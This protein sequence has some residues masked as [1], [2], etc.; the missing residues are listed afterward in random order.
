[1]TA[2]TLFTNHYLHDFI[3]RSDGVDHF[4]A[5]D[6]FSEDG[7][8]AIQMLCVGAVVADEELLTAGVLSGMRH[9]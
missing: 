6:N 7:M 9:R 8:Y 5:I 3:A 1:L 2:K 4:Q